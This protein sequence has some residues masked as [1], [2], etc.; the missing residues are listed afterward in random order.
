[1]NTFI[2]PNQLD[3][4]L[5]I[6]GLI[7][8][9]ISHS[10]AFTTQSVFLLMVTTVIFIALNLKD[11]KRYI[12]LLTLLAFALILLSLLSWIFDRSISTEY[13]IINFFRWLSLIA[14]SSAV[15][16]SL[17]S[18]EIIV[19]LRWFKAPTGIAVALG[20]GIRFL[21]VIIEDAKRVYWVMMQSNSMKNKAGLS[22]YLTA[23]LD[24]AQNLIVAVVRSIDDIIVSITVQDLEK[25]IDDFQFKNLNSLDWSMLCL[26]VSTTLYILYSFSTGQKILPI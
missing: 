18:L 13:L 4:R 6:F 1:L 17:N 21:P 26:F 24:F 12:N 5:K 8:V 7:L 3:P 19:A 16:Y 15:F 22:K 10:V 11:S 25:R 2:P 23:M 9:S 14:F 20:T